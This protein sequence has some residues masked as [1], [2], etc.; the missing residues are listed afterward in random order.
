M[1][2]GHDTWETQYLPRVD[3]W[4]AG[5]TETVHPAEG[6][7]HMSAAFSSYL[8]GEFSIHILADLWGFPKLACENNSIPPG[9]QVDHG[10]KNQFNRI[11]CACVK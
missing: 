7:R 6:I 1:K 3:G 4:R 9:D 10:T 2:T 8:F 5:A 11:R